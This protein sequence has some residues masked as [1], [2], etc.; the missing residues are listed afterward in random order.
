MS[1]LIQI[2]DVDVAVRDELKVRA[3]EQGVSL[4]SYLRS[5]LED[6]V[7]VPP[8]GTTL[9][10]IARRGGISESSSDVVRRLRDAEAPRR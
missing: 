6:A 9:S 3:A 10:R 7:A 8:L 5:L 4:N 1:V 2:R